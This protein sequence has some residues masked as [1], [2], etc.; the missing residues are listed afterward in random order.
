MHFS[1]VEEKLR[2]YWKAREERKRMV[3]EKYERLQPHLRE[4]G[5]RL[6]AANE[7]R[8]FGRGGV[9]GG[10]R[11]VAEALTIS[12]KT[13]MQGKRELPAPLPLPR[14]RSGRRPTASPGGGRK[15][16]LAIYPEMRA[17]I[18]QIVDAR[19]SAESAEAVAVRLE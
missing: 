5:T 9:R 7:A 4:R 1:A 8:S 12:C 14:Q 3:R 11:A 18:E 2:L 13:V 6:R 17:R 16:I 15:S 10:V 19:G